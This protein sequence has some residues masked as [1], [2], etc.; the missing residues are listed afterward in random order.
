M[1]RNRRNKKLNINLTKIIE[2]EIKENSLRQSFPKSIDSYIKDL[3]SKN[4]NTHEDL[5]EIPFVTI[6][7]E[8]S[9]DFDDAVW[10]TNDIKQTKIRVAIADVSFYVKK[11]DPLDLE[12][13]KRGNSFYFPDRVLPMFPKK[14]SNDICSLIPNKERAC[15]VI[16]VIIKNYKISS[17]TI[18]RAKIRS[19]ARLTYKEV[20]QIYFSNISQNKYFHLIKNLF[21][22]FSVLRNISEK[23]NK[24]EFDS[25]EFELI[26]ELDD[27]FFFKKKE[28]LI[29][30]K[31]IEEFMVLAN[32]VIAKFLKNNNLDSIFRNHEK[33]KDEKIEELKKVLKH[34][35]IYNNEKFNKQQ[36]FNN[37]LRKI[38]KNNSFLN[39]SLLRSQTKA[40][41]SNENFGHFGLGLDY[42]T[43]FT[44]PIRRYSDLNVHRDLIDFFFYK[45]TN[46]YERFLSNHLTL[47]EK[48]SDY[49]ERKIIERACSLYLRNSKKRYFK[50]IVDGIESWGIFIKAIDL[51]FSCLARIRSKNLGSDKKNYLKHNTNFQIG[52]IVSFKIKKN[53]INTGKILVDKVKLISEK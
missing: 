8:E 28:K 20:D 44:S 21:E 5:T 7:G 11:N 12:A 9:M 43:H 45:K 48:K 46:K 51:P 22:S 31:L 41:Y 53:D 26:R 37:I 6:D 24:I 23:R 27:S 38:K 3:K 52:Q 50:G 1:K 17:F 13:K 34:N 36:D 49:I 4:L 42:Y 32:E 15:I 2:S 39:D 33:P 16:E 29:S 30:Y 19:V 47:Q 25:E 10:S 35:G 40:Y 18:H 14:I